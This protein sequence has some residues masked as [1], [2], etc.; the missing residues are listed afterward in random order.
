NKGRRQVV[1]LG[2]SMD[3][4]INAAKDLGLIDTSKFQLQGRPKEVKATIDAVAK[5]PEKYLVLSTGNQGEPNSV[6]SRI[7]NKEYKFKFRKEDQVIFSSMTIPTPINKANRYVIERNLK[8][9]G[10]RILKDVHVSGHAMREDHRD[11]LRILNPEKVIPMHGETERLASFAS[12]CEEEG[13]IIGD[14]VHIMTDGR[15]VNIK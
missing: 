13:F 15:Y 7:A 14:T 1:V 2:R 12:L 11:L 5:N 6:L 10:V 9:Q 3:N 8:E 4:Y